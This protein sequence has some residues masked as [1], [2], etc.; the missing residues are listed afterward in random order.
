MVPSALPDGLPA[1]DDGALPAWVA[2]SPD[3]GRGVGV[4]LHVP[5][6]TVRCGYCDFN[7]YTASQLGGG[8]SQASYADTLLTEVELARG[9]GVEVAVAAAHRAE[10]HVQ[11]HADAASGVGRPGHPGRQRA[12]VG[13]RKPVRER[14]GDHPPIVPSARSGRS[15]PLVETLETLASF[16]AEGKVRYLGWSN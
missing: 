13:R 14:A 12:V 5:F 3:A 16:V 7:T 6:C 11:V 4:Y 1:P 2:G 9:V 10:R 8:A 15:T